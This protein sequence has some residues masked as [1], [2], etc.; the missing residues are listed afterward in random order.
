MVYGLSEKTMIVYSS[1][2]TSPNPK[3]KE[4]IIQILFDI[5]FLFE[6]FSWRK[7][8][9]SVKEKKELRD[10]INFLKGVT[11]SNSPDEFGEIINWNNKVNKLMEEYE[12]Q[13][14]IL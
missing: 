10:I 8:I 2:L 1:F 13:V 14:I 11:A 6:V 7:E 4:G 12:N 3:N 5:Q 9:E